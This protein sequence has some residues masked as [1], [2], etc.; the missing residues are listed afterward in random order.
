MCLT[1][2]HFFGQKLDHVLQIFLLLLVNFFESANFRFF[3]YVLIVLILQLLSLF[4]HWLTKFFIWI[5]V[6]CSYYSGFSFSTFKSLNSLNKLLIFN[7]EHF[8]FFNQLIF[9]HSLWCLLSLMHYGL[10]LSNTFSSICSTRVLL[11]GLKKLLIGRNNIKDESD[12]DSTSNVNLWNLII[13]SNLGRHI[14]FFGSKY[15]R[16]LVTDM[17][18]SL[19]MARLL[20]PAASFCLPELRHSF[21]LLFSAFGFT[22]RHWILLSCGCL[23]ASSLPFNRDLLIYLLFRCDGKDA[24]GNP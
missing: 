19:E 16:L 5:W 18:H 9:L 8:N 22:T 13:S 7:S 20:F 2:D 15:S 12:W 3:F 14:E 24:H 6:I 17:L 11:R 4:S 21:K 1:L 23:L 10:L